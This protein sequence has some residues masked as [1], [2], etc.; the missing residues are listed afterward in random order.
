MRDIAIANG[1]IAAIGDLAQAS[2]GEVID[3]RA[4]HVLP[5]VVI[6]CAYCLTRVSENSPL[7]MRTASPSANRAEASSP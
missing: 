3:C 1:R 2:A 5:G 4:L 6:A 7:R